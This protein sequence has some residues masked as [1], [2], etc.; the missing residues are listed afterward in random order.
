[1]KVF[2]RTLDSSERICKQL[3]KTPISAC[4]LGNGL[5]AP[6]QL[7]LSYEKQSLN[8]RRMK[9]L[10]GLLLCKS[11]M[12]GTVELLSLL[13]ADNHVSVN[14]LGVLSGTFN[15]NGVSFFLKLSTR[16]GV[17]PLLFKAISDV[18]CI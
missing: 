15:A 14:L 13:P 9:L 1:M 7:L 18:T 10:S 16:V 2:V 17:L 8:F 4:C 3:M 12:L 6:R 5:T 11:V